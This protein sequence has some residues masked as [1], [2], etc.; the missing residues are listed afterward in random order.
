[1]GTAVNPT[2]EIS[3]TVAAH[4]LADDRLVLRVAEAFEGWYRTN[5]AAALGDDA[6]AIANVA[7]RRLDDRE[8]RPF[9]IRQALARRAS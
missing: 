2:H 3:I 9:S 4:H 8:A 6:P 7:V 1:M 5:A